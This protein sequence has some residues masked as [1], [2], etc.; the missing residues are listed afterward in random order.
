MIEA[1]AYRIGEVWSEDMSLFRR[2]NLSGGQ[3][4]E[5]DIIQSIRGGVRRAV[6]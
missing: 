6:E 3:R 4:V 1:E 2:N 5:L